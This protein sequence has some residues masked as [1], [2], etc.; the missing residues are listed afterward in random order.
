MLSG[1]SYD[2]SPEAK[3]EMANAEQIFVFIF[4]IESLLKIQALGM[5]LYLRR[6]LTI[7]GINIK[8]LDEAQN[9]W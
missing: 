8:K 1:E 9:L 3:K 5:T 6:C 4:W 7:C 2:V